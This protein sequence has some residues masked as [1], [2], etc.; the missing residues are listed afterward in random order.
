MKVENQNIVRISVRNLVEFIMRNGDIDNRTGTAQVK[1]AML[2]GGRIHRK[3][4]RQMGSSYRAEVS[5]KTEVEF[6]DLCIRVEGR[7]DGVIEEDGEITIDE[8][9]GILG[10]LKLLRE[11]VKVHEAQAKCYAWMAAKEKGLK[12]IR[13][14]ITY[15]QMETEE[16][17]RFQKTIDM[18][19]LEEW[20]LGLV[21]AYEKWARF[22]IEWKK[23]RNASIKKT[24]FPYA[25]RSG[26][27]EL[28]SNVYRTI[29]S[30]K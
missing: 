27:K 4:Q 28:V 23:E 22:R 21:A 18:D 20:F 11:P 2:M 19:I 16:I 26:Q 3:I 10:E 17:K 15:C 8:I 1:D 12:K 25:Q 24:E 14:Q 30:Q 6:E 9:K 5:M 13:I 29:L 7:A